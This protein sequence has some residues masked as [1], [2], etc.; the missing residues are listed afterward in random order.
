MK[1]SELKSFIKDCIRGSVVEAKKMSV[2]DLHKKTHTMT[3]SQREKFLAKYRV[4]PRCDGV[5]P[6]NLKGCPACKAM[7]SEIDEEKERNYKDEYA[8]YHS[9]PEQKK[10]RAKRNAARKKLEREGRVKKGDGKDVDHKR[11][12]RSGGS[13]NDSNLRVRDRHSNRGDK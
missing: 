12:L 10:N 3:Q 1:R 4:C 9:K 2:D 5:F 13:N 8:N 11:K 6:A 7:A